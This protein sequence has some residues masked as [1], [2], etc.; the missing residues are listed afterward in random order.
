MSA[1]AD[2]LK[3][4]IAAAI[5]FANRTGGSVEFR[6]ANFA[7]HLA[8]GLRVDLGVHDPVVSALRQLVG[9]PL[10]PKNCCLDGAISC[11]S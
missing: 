8:G 9:L 4:V 2:D 6:S 1:T 5:D 7:A 3:S 11:A 10:V